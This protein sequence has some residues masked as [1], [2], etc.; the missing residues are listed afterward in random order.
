[1]TAPY[2]RTWQSSRIQ[3]LKQSC[4]RHVKQLIHLCTTCC[5]YACVKAGRESSSKACWNAHLKLGRSDVRDSDATI[6]SWQLQHTFT[7]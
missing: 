2:M 5:M 1:M 3:L 4:A 6:P 7:W